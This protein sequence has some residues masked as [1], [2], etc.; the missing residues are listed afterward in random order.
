MGLVKIDTIHPVYDCTLYVESGAIVL[1]ELTPQILP[2]VVFDGALDLAARNEQLKDLSRTSRGRKHASC[3][4]RVLLRNH[5]AAAS[6][7]QCL[8]ASCSDLAPRS[9]VII[10]NR[11]PFGHARNSRPRR[12]DI[13][14]VTMFADRRADICILK[15]L[16]PAS[17][18]ASR[19]W[20]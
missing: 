20:R 1:R 2:D 9:L 17:T 6:R 18:W 8:P 12:T 3:S 19:L 13:D 10:K 11:F 15:D 5:S 14:F 4:Q 16:H 7:H